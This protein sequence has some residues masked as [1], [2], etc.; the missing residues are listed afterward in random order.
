[1]EFYQRHSLRDCFKALDT[2]LVVAF[3]EPERRAGPWAHGGT[4]GQS[5][6]MGGSQW[7]GEVG[8]RLWGPTIGV[9]VGWR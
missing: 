8:W 1:M 2:T 9:M 5:G 6:D 7:R 3:K 4:W